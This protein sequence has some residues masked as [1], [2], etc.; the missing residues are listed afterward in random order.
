MKKLF[1]LCMLQ[2]FVGA[3]LFAAKEVKLPVDPSLVHGELANGMKYVLRKNSKPP[4]KMSIWLHVDSGSLD[5]EDDQRGLAHF[6]EHMAFNGSENFP[7]GQLIKYFESIGLTFGLHQN[8]FTSFDQTT[9]SLA[10]PNT[11]KDTMD[12]GFLCM[13]DFAYRL[14]LTEDEINRERGVIQEEEVACD[15]LGYRMMMKSL[16]MIFPEAH[17]AKRMPIGDMDVVRTAP[18]QRFVDY[19]KKWYTPKNSTV[20]VVGDFDVKEAEA[21]IK[22]NFS[23]WVQPQEIAV[24]A[25]P[26]VKPYTETRIEILK[27]KELT[28][29]E[30]TLYT[31]EPGVEV[32]DNEKNYQSL[33]EDQV[34][35]YMVNQRLRLLREKGEADFLSASIYHGDIFRTA[36]MG[37]ISVNAKPEKWD[38]AVRQVMTELKRVE[39]HGFYQSELDKAIKKQLSD[40]ERSIQN[41]ANKSN[42]DIIGAINSSVNQGYLPMAPVQEKPILER[43][44]KQLDIVSLHK[45][46]KQDF[47]GANYLAMAQFPE[48]DGLETPNKE[49]IAAL[50]EDIKKI[51][52]EAS[53]EQ[54]ATANILNHE[55]KSKVANESDFHDSLG[56]TTLHYA[57]GCKC[58]HREM[59]YKKEKVLVRATIA[60]GRLEEGKN[61]I[62]ISHFASAILSKPSSNNVSFSEI[63]D[64]RVG[65]KFNLHASVNDTHL[66]LSLSSDKKDLEQGVR[67]MYLYLTDFKVEEKLFEQVLQDLRLTYDQLDKNSSLMMNKALRENLWS[68][69][70]RLKLL[71]SRES[72]EKMTAKQ[73]QAWIRKKFAK[74]PIEVS[75]VGD[76]DLKEAKRL[77][78]K[79]FGSLN[80]RRD[81]AELTEAFKLKNA[82][83][84]QD[85]DVP[86][87]TKDQ[88]CIVVGGWTV[89]DANDQENLALYLAGKIARTRLF[90]VI[91]EEE[92]L[93]YSVSSGFSS[94]K[95]LRNMSKF[96]IYFT[97]QVENAKKAA[98]MAREVVED[99]RD[100]G[101][102]ESEMS[103]VH[104]QIENLLEEDLVKPSFWS[105]KLGNQDLYETD[106][107]F[108]EKI[109]EHY[110]NVSADD[111]KVVMQRYFQDPNFFQVITR[112]ESTEK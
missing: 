112:P 39:Q 71:P 48:K 89:A 16:P 88:K 68:H 85:L 25:K 60:G 38:S 84:P 40:M 21:L 86:V 28:S 5:E 105:A 41:E 87:Q 35:A 96:Y 17:I 3:S 51:Q 62:G 98:K 100:E 93:T 74:N 80:K 92:N 37:H 6:L 94:T 2:F 73:V 43:M 61:E 30:L 104:K 101:P 66:S 56:I 42:K 109:Q 22:K 106:M 4:G 45:L 12:K 57:N 26:G 52:T 99:L 1:V 11:E 67:L 75:I 111:V 103:Q 29:S 33:I 72:I 31:I 79:Y 59:D 14:L 10:L 108:I 32:I 49:A 20:M 107:A 64:W 36:M 83:T 50:L 47:C 91:R 34:L 53:V 110:A 82:K 46:F 58:R 70:P 90:K 44:L 102:S 97:A 54:Q 81:L 18:R 76:V 19:Y 27:D 63:N 69:E 77:T 95:R 23:A 8:A 7:P 24:H 13:S 9:Y 55:P 78:D 15:S 65:K